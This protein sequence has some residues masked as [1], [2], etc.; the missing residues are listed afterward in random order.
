MSWDE[1]RSR[2]RVAKNN[3]SDLEVNV[4]DL[5]REMEFSNLGVR[6]ARR[7]WGVH[8]Y[9][10]V[11]NFH[12]CVQ[13]AAGDVDRQKKVV[14]AASVLRRVQGEVLKLPEYE[15]GKIQM[16][17]ARLH[18]L[19]FKPF[20]TGDDAEATRAERATVLAITLQSYLYDVFNPAFHDIDNF[21]GV[22]GLDAGSCLITNPGFRGERERICLGTPA[23]VAAKILG[24]SGSIVLTAQVYDRLPTAL[25]DRFEKAGQVAGAFTYRATGLR[26]STDPDLADELGVTFDTERWNERT[27]EL[28]GE[29]PLASMDISE[30]VAKIDVDVLTE[31]NSRRTDAIAI[32]ADLDG[33]TRYVEQAEDDG[34][35][36]SLVRALHMI[37]NEFHAVV[38]SDFDGLALQHQ[39]DRLFAIAHLPTG[40]DQKMR[41]QRCRAAVDQA[42]GLQSSMEHTLREELPGRKEL[43]VAVGLA[44][45]RLLVTRLGKKGK[46]EVVCLG[47]E[48]AEAERLQLRSSGGETRISATLYELLENGGVKEEF[49][50]KDG[51]YS[52]TGITFPRLDEKEEEAAAMAG[53][54]TAVARGDRVSPVTDAGQSP[55]P[56]SG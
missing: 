17:A 55:R 41:Q 32:Y 35:V 26:W 21:R 54:L 25:Q 45:G 14:R 1:Q 37:R 31:R 49:E 7:A 3:F 9:A 34:E 20:G 28:R 18:G 8:L 24:A 27:R 43:H 30:A 48:V 11:P 2:E 5:T 56:W 38:Q 46:R 4:A 40:S 12:L 51:A 53:T 13:D 52:A 29:L 33:F 15:T 44:I 47:P 39:G 6:D 23:N 19:C 42:I 10:D 50:K 16:Q 22:V 36:V